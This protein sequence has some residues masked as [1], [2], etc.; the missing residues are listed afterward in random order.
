M[1]YQLNG[2]LPPKPNDIP[3]APTANPDT[4]SGLIKG[5]TI[6]AIDV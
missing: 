2:D 4:K 5:P 6:T 3:K 1:F